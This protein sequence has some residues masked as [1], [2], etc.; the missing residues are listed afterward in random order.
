MDKIKSIEALARHAI[1]TLPDS[2]A[3]RKRLL[4]AITMALPRDNE[5]RTDAQA[6]LL[7]IKH[8]DDLQAELTLCRA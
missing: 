2:I 3:E 6:I 8:Q 4:T 5:T 1:S 7:A